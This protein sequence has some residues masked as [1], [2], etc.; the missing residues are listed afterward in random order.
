M[1]VK[2]KILVAED[3]AASAQMLGI[4]LRMNDY[5]VDV[6]GLRRRRSSGRRRAS[7]RPPLIDLT[8]PG[9]TTTEF[10][11]ALQQVAS[12]PPLVV[13]SARAASE[14]LEAAALLGAVEALQKPADIDVILS[15]IAGA[16]N[17]HTVGWSG[18]THRS[19][20]RMSIFRRPGTRLGRLFA[21]ALALSAAA[22]VHSAQADTFRITTV[23]GSGRWEP[24]PA[25]GAADA[26]NINQPF[27]IEV[28]AD[29]S[30]VICGV[31]HGRVFRLDPAGKRLTLVAGNGK[32]GYIPATAAWPS[33]PRCRSPTRSAST[34]PATCTSWT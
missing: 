23:A 21:S 4:L 32:K 8:L 29:G 22:A 31:G 9:M 10:V 11:A 33:T 12:R 28:A 13:Y 14:L 7:T 15:A 2:L 6:A 24:G 30:L 3:D 5:D 20:T 18:V 34:R 17:G 19:T 1:D 16:V 25:E 27:G 26:V